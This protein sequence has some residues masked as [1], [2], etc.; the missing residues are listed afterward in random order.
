[1]IDNNEILRLKER[2]RIEDVLSHLGISLTKKGRRLYCLCPFHDDHH[3]SLSIDTEKNFYYCPVCHE[4]GDGVTLMMKVNNLS[5]IDALKQIASIYGM[6]LH[7]VTD[8]ISIAQKKHQD[9]MEQIRMQ[10]E[11]IVKAAAEHMFSPENP[12]YT[13]LHNRGFSDDT[14]RAYCVGHYSPIDSETETDG[15]FHKSYDARQMAGRI[16]FPWYSTSNMIVGLS[17]RVL[18]ER[19]K[20]VA[21]KYVNSSEKSG[22][23]KGNYLYGL[24]LAIRSITK[25]KRVYVVEGYTDVMAMHQAGVENVVAVCG[26]A[27]TDAQARLLKRYA[28]EVVLCLDNDVAG[29]KA[30]DLAAQ[31]L[32]PLDVKVEILHASP[33]GDPADMLLTQGEQ[34]ILDWTHNDTHNL[35]DICLDNFLQASVMNPYTRRSYL[36]KLLSYLSKICD[37]ILRAFYIEKCLKVSP[38]LKEQDLQKLLEP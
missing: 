10:R 1:M 3:P 38:Y 5:Y 6:Q 29:I 31:K 34:A 12:A 37:P 24:N 14:L 35:L 19:T 20:G 18:D 36:H 21:A 2:I 8:D 32:L 4:H 9:F 17:G 11:A 16:V 26:T 13:Y 22:F 30:M 28:D 15:L 27:L 25:E 23:I 7:E 33:G